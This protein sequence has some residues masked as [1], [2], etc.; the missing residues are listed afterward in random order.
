[1]LHAAHI[2]RAHLFCWV[3]SVADVVGGVVVVVVCMVD[4][5]TIKTRR[6]IYLFSTSF[7]CDPV[8]AT[9]TL[10]TIFRNIQ[11]YT[12]QIKFSE[13]QR[14]MQNKNRKTFRQLSMQREHGRWVLVL[15]YTPYSLFT[16]IW[17][18]FRTEFNLER[19]KIERKKN[20]EQVKHWVALRVTYFREQRDR[21][22][23]LRIPH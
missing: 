9:A 22:V 10:F 11:S 17:V 14:W 18:R 21:Q 3:S 8:H 16:Q 15:P 1:M 2:Q 19:I 23:C 12:R 4:R 20:T 13:H 6:Y 5:C 7:A